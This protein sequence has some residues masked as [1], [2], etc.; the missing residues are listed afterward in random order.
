M[1]VIQITDQSEENTMHGRDTWAH[2]KDQMIDEKAMNQT[3][4]ETRKSLRDYEKDIAKNIKTNP[5]L[6]V[7]TKLK[8]TGEVPHL[9]GNDDRN[10]WGQ[11]KWTKHILHKCI[12][13]RTRSI[14]NQRTMSFH[15]STF[16]HSNRPWRHHTKTEED[17]PKQSTWSG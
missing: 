16:L 17:E 12:Y 5:N 14:T 3:R 9:K 10:R 15:Q 8:T 4:N 11:S 13:P 7:P 2:M 6:Y 1:D